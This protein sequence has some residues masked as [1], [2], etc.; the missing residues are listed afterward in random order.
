A[1][2]ESLDLLYQEQQKENERL[3]NEM[4][5][6]RSKFQQKVLD[7]YKEENAMLTEQLTAL[8][9]REKELESKIVELESALANEPLQQTGD[10]ESA[11]SIAE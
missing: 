4:K 7:S 6:S 9:L 5:K 3:K 1:Q 8:Q 10:E 11:D 2:Y